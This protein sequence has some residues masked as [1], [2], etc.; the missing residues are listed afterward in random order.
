MPQ[1]YNVSYLESRRREANR[2]GASHGCPVAGDVE[3]SYIGRRWCSI[4]GK[5][6]SDGQPL[7]T[8]SVDGVLYLEFAAHGSERFVRLADVGAVARTRP[9]PRATR[10]S[11]LRGTTWYV[12]AAAGWRWNEGRMG[13]LRRS[14]AEMGRNESGQ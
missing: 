3:D 12:G 13:C 7:G 2:Q 10:A 14:S 4:L 5:S 8:P 1:V 9:T 6:I 11:L